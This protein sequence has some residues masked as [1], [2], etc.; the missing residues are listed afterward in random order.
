MNGEVIFALLCF[1]LALA[2]S[3]CLRTM[4]FN[5]T[6]NE[7]ARSSRQLR[8]IWR[9]MVTIP[10]TWEIR[11]QSTSSSSL[12]LWRER[13][14]STWSLALADT[15]RD[16]LFSV[17]SWRAGRAWA[18]VMIP[19]MRSENAVLGT[20]VNDNPMTPFVC[21][22]LPN[23]PKPLSGTLVDEKRERTTG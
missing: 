23:H 6:K 22:S 15:T 19:S 16:V 11:S 9:S 10:R 7:Q 3:A 5:V 8:H 20:D 17:S 12:K 14:F 18:V 21:E 13:T 2:F 4:K 1:V